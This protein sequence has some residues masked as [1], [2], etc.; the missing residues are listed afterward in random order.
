MPGESFKA[1]LS[2]TSAPT[3]PAADSAAQYLIDID[4]LPNSPPCKKESA[5][6]MPITGFD[7][8]EVSMNGDEIPKLRINEA[9]EYMIVQ[10]TS[11]ISNEVDTT[12]TI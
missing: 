5:G 7:K 9:V 10:N 4:M 11:S 1:L 6:Q 12:E 3:T 2:P 8:E